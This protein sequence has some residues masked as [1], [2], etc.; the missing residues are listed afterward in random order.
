MCYLATTTLFSYDFL[1]P[2][3][4]SL[5][6]VLFSRQTGFVSP[7]PACFSSFQLNQGLT[8]P[9]R[10][11][12]LPLYISVQSGTDVSCPFFVHWGAT[13]PC[14]RGFNCANRVGGSKKGNVELGTVRI[15]QLKW[16]IYFS[17]RSMKI[18]IFW[19]TTDNYHF[20]NLLFWSLNVLFSSYR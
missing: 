8:A 2:P 5:H 17:F 16:F 9:R 1:S 15:I 10:G 7:A 4:C 18:Y 11:K 6:L 19:L 12:N 13:L 3:P 14:F 20:R